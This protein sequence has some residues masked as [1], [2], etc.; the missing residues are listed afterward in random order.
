MKYTCNSCNYSTDDSGNW[1]KHKKTKSHI[2]SVQE[3]D[4]SNLMV[5]VPKD[6]LAHLMAK[7]STDIKKYVCPFCDEVFSSGS[8]LSRHKHH[9]CSKNKTNSKTDSKT[10]SKTENNKIIIELRTKIDELEKQ[11]DELEKQNLELRD[12]KQCLKTIVDKAQNV[13]SASVG[14]LGYIIAN[15]TKAPLLEPMQTKEI[16]NYC[17][18]EKKEIAIVI[19][20]LHRD[21]ELLEYLGNLFISIYKKKNPDEQSLWNSDCSRLNYVIRTIVCGGVSWIT[22]KKGIKLKESVIKPTLEFI[23]RELWNYISTHNQ[24]TIKS[25]ENIS[26]CCNAYKCV[27]EPSFSDDL[28]KFLAPHFQLYRTKEFPAITEKKIMLLE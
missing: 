11:N 6:L 22:D 25:I 5:N 26:Y 19:S 23:E 14:A 20:E 24:N 1:S 27:R 17:G 2:K 12:D 4:V 15:F 9:R 18:G 8:C 7:Y 10:G 21:G 28:I 16:E 13:A 3:N